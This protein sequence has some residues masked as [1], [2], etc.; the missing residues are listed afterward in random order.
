M[1]NFCLPCAAAAAA[2]AAASDRLEPYGEAVAVL[3]FA[4][5]EAG[6]RARHLRHPQ[7]CLD[8]IQMGVERGGQTGLVKVCC[9]CSSCTVAVASA[10]LE[11]LHGAIC[12]GACADA[13]YDACA[14][15][16]YDETIP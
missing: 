16:V 10:W 12:F 15:A 14:D 8:A 9:Q 1:G 4:R 5:A 7:L 11:V 2:A 13:V 3:E 6:K